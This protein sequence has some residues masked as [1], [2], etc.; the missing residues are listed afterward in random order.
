VKTP[1]GLLAVVCVSALQPMQSP[2]IRSDDE[3]EASYLR[4]LPDL[5]RP[6][7]AFTST[8]AMAKVEHWR[9]RVIL[10]LGCQALAEGSSTLSA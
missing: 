8:L 3:R 10:R 6:E 5:D 7:A 1:Y 9:A 4:V 2:R